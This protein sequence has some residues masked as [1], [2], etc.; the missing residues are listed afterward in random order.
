MPCVSFS[1]DS[2]K[3]TAPSGTW[4]AQ[5]F[6]PHADYMV[7]PVTWLALWLVTK[8][9]APGWKVI[10]LCLSLAGCV[11]LACSH[12]PPGVPH[13]ALMLAYVSDIKYQVLCCICIHQV[14]NTDVCS[15]LQH[16]CPLPNVAAGRQQGYGLY[17]VYCNAKSPLQKVSP[18]AHG[19]ATSMAR[20]RAGRTSRHNT[21]EGRKEKPARMVARF[22]A[23]RALLEAIGWSSKNTMDKYYLHV[24][25]LSCT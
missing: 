21:Y 17:P 22:A 10:S 7:C 18:A 6:A 24:G 2:G 9:E 1:K 15:C 25:L 11:F 12:M 8:H 4:E 16:A 5:V 3:T 14:L 23:C 19:Y 20:A 13:A